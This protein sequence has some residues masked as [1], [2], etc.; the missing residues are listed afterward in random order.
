M[1]HLQGE[2]GNRRQN[3]RVAMQAHISPALPKALDG[4]KQKEKSRSL[5][6]VINK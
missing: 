3:A 5:F 6:I 2:S 1:L 4:K